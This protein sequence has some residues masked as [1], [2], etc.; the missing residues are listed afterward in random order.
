[1]NRILKLLESLSRKSVVGTLVL[2]QKKRSFEVFIED[3][4]LHIFGRKHLEKIDLHGLLDLEILGGK[5]SETSLETIVLAT[6]LSST[7]LPEALHSRGL[8]GAGEFEELARRHFREE[9]FQRLIS[10]PESFFFQEGYV[11]DS[12]IGQSSVSLEHPVHLDS[13]IELLQQRTEHLRL[14]REL[15]PNHDEVLVLTEKGMARKQEASWDFGFQKI[16]TLID[17][18]RNLRSVVD[19]GYLFRFYVES[20]IVE[21]LREGWI[22][23][24]LIP[25]LR[26]VDPTRL[27]RTDAERY[28]PL[29]KTA[30]KYGTDEIGAREGLAKLLIR[31]DRKDEATNQYNFMGDTLYRMGK[32]GKAIR[33]YFEG[34]A[35]KPND[36]LISEKVLRIYVAEA[37]EKAAQGN[38][39]ES[40]ELYRHALE[41]RPDSVQVYHALIDVLR[42]RQETSRVIDLCDQATSRSRLNGDITVAAETIRHAVAL[43]PANPIFHKKLINLFLDFHRTAEALDEMEKL[44]KLYIAGGKRDQGAILI[45]KILRTD[46]N[47]KHLWEHSKTPPRH[48]RKQARAFWKKLAV[49]YSLV[50]LLAFGLYQYWTFRELEPLRK[51]QVFAL[52]DPDWIRTESTLDGLLSSGLEHRL[53]E[54]VAATEDF[55]RTYPMSLLRY[56]ARYLREQFEAAVGRLESV[57]E[58]RKK[59]IFDRGR[60]L[61]SEGSFDEARALLRL[62]RTCPEGDVWRQRAEEELVNNQK[63][64]ERAFAIFQKAEQAL[65]EGD[66]V[67]SHRLMNHLLSDYPLAGII[68]KIFFPVKVETIP[69]GGALLPDGQDAP[70]HSPHIFNVTPGTPRMLTV[71]HPGFDST[72]IELAPDLG[73]TLVVRLRQRPLWERN[74]LVVEKHAP[75]MKTDT[76]FTISRD[77]GLYALDL[78]DGSIRWTHRMKDLIEP[79][80]APRAGGDYLLLPLNNGKILRFLPDSRPAG[81]FTLNGLITTQI[82]RLD[83]G[84]TLAF[85]S[86]G[87]LLEFDP[88]RNSTIRSVT[89]ENTTPIRL[90]PCG[91]AGLLGL[92]ANDRVFRADFVR[93]E[94]LWSISFKE[95]V[96]RGPVL[97]GNPNNGEVMVLTTSNQLF[98]LSPTRG[99]VQRILDLP[100]RASA[101]FFRPG[102]SEVLVFGDDGVLTEIDAGVVGQPRHRPHANRIVFGG[103]VVRVEEIGEQLGLFKTDGAF[104]LLDGE[105][106]QPLW[107]YSPG[108]TESGIASAA[109]DGR[110]LA[111]V[112]SRGT[113]RLFLISERAAGE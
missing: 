34:L 7:T 5:I 113:L 105:T 81:E 24:S 74:D 101:T 63:Y 65:G 33:A 20:R 110:S 2:G 61:L 95:R 42:Q 106:L 77:G 111:L 16:L 43:F 62:L 19:D 8:I 9:L 107:N 87:S 17:G 99:T 28:L 30:I 67:R 76:L 39:R 18:F 90:W 27:T 11:P 21:G 68:R 13:F 54:L 1:M 41:I 78:A 66:W 46:P 71:S 112:D 97:S 96:A 53:R 108:S 79:I 38:T 103:G 86:R 32:R 98:F 75:L 83:A 57:R 102:R 48:V 104:Y 72:T 69:P 29:F 94:V 109:L 14:I 6:D 70:L 50:A 49:R 4:L 26:H 45:D 60:R 85:G 40:V 10:D 47:R 80:S 12:I 91:N 25:E 100:G 35:L 55:E 64:E 3:K 73:P 92:D 52:S 84:A 93:G 44:A 89:L 82:V 22:K 56:E 51:E 88:N 15:I 23:K 31:L 37:Q 36:P 59:E 58:S